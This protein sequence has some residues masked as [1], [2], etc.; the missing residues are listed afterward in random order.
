MRKITIGH[1]SVGE[2]EPTFIIAEA[3]SN[4]DGKLEQA[5]KLIDIAA[6]A[7]AQ[8]M[9]KTPRAKITRP[10]I[11]FLVVCKDLMVFLLSS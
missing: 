2:G 5:N 7:G 3:G 8:L 4:H 1:K 10:A 11:G 9:L 6:W